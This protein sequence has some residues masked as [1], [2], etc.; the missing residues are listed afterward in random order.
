MHNQSFIIEHPFNIGG[1]AGKF[2]QQLKIYNP[3]LQIQ[4]INPLKVRK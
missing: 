2:G 4:N 1:E 3:P